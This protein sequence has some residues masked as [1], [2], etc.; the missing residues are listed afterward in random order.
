M[1]NWQREYEKRTTCFAALIV[2][3]IVIGSCVAAA[4]WYLAVSVG[5]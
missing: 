1:D 5:G 2:T 3:A 4:V